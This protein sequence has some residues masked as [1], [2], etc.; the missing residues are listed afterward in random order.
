MDGNPGNVAQKNQEV[1]LIKRISTSTKT[2]YFGVFRTLLVLGV[3]YEARLLEREV[4]GG[5]TVVAYGQL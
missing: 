5:R 3:C 1:L 2:G 4:G